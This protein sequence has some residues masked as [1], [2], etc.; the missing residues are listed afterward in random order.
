ME[1]LF[2]DSKALLFAYEPILLRVPFSYFLR[3]LCRGMAQP[4]AL[5]GRP[6]MVLFSFL[7]AAET[8]GEDGKAE[9][10]GDAV[11]HK[12]SLP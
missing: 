10:P 9:A 4:P 5:L 1:S 6:D 12:E 7:D 8:E 2:R 11:G 3:C